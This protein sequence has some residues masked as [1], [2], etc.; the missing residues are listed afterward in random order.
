MAK[1]LFGGLFGGQGL[2]MV[3][4]LTKQNMEKLQASK[5]HDEKNSE[6][7]PLRKLRDAIKK[8]NSKPHWKTPVGLYFSDCFPPKFSYIQVLKI[9]HYG[10][11]NQLCNILYTYHPYI[12]HIHIWLKKG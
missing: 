12:D 4:K 6:D 1:G 2:Q 11:R 5:P 7:S 3:G 9:S 8:V 10:K